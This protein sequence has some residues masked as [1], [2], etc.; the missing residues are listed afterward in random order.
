MRYYTDCRETPSVQ[1][2]TVT[3]FADS[4]EEVKEAAVQHAIEVHGHEDSQ[5]LRQETEKQIRQTEQDV[6]AS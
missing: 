4:K 5:E 6:P 3:I 2:C 1:N